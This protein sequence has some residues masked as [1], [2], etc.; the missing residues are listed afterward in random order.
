[1]SDTA[2]VISWAKGIAARRAPGRRVSLA[3]LYGIPLLN[4]L[5]LAALGAAVC[6]RATTAP[7]M[8]LELPTAE[9]RD[10]ASTP[11]FAALTYAPG[12]KSPLVFFDSI[13]Y[14]LD[15]PVEDDA[16]VKAI[17]AAIRESGHDDITLYADGSARHG[18]TIRFAEIARRAGAS[19]VNLAI[20]EDA[21]Q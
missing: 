6:S 15:D 10:G 19:V 7:A 9:F 12:S 4:L 21:A 1:M 16:L 11:L 3:L 14:R 5:A 2:T 20:K 17:A 13:R 8:R 18:M